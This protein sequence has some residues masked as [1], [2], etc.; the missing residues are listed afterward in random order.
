MRLTITSGVVILFSVAIA[1]C[2]RNLADL[3]EQSGAWIQPAPGKVLSVTGCDFS[4]SVDSKTFERSDYV[5]CID[6]P[7][8]QRFY[9]HRRVIGVRIDR[10][11]RFVLINL[12]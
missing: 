5:T 9:Q 7:K 1:A 2:A 12:F 8:R 11:H 3:N 6:H 4:E 10:T